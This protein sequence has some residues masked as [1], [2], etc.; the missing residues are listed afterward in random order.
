M[1]LP[2]AFHYTPAPVPVA[3]LA[4]LHET[5][6]QDTGGSQ[7]ARN[8]LFWLAGFPDPTGYQ[9][10]GGL[11]LRRLDAERKEA[12]AAVLR[13]WIGPTHSDDP[14]YA[15]LRDIEVKWGTVGPIP[16][17]PGT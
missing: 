8:F 13:W 16:E 10:E 17:V 14:L 5:A 7:A 3:A 11:E 4:L 9:G 2:A 15:I 12:A 6:L 1:K